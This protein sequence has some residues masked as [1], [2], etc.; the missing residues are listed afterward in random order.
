MIRASGTPLTVYGELRRCPIVL[1]GYKYYVNLEIA[2]LGTT[3]RAI[4]GM[5]FLKAYEAKINLETDQ[6]RRKA[7]TVFNTLLEDSAE[8]ISVWLC[9]DCTLSTGHINR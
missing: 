9:E 6:V 4:L 7:G 8:P 2:D 5:D 1:N 3:V